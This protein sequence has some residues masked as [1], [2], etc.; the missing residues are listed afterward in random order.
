[1]DRLRL[2]LNLSMTNEN[3]RIH[4]AVAAGRPGRGK[5]APWPAGRCPLHRVRGQARVGSLLMDH[6]RLPPLLPPLLRA[7]A[8]PKLNRA[9]S[10]V[11][12]APVSPS[13]PVLSELHFKVC[14]RS[15]VCD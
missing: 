13:V 7:P 14:H 10:R 12:P 1:M 6:L 5:S 2:A 4:V 15:P 8:L 11:Y 9:L 3:D